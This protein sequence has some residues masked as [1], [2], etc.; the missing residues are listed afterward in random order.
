[1][2]DKDLEKLQAIANTVT[3][4]WTREALKEELKKKNFNDWAA[5]SNKLA[6]E[7]AY[8]SLKLHSGDTLTAQYTER[9]RILIDHQIALGGYRLADALV[10][11][12]QGQKTSSSQANTEDLR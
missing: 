11:M 6:F 8:D 9:A 3:T 12:L 2:S 5:E 7:F 10:E 4:K 1:M